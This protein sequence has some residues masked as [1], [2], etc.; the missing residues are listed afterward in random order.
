MRAAV[1]PTIACFFAHPALAQDAADAGWTAQTPQSGLQA[2]RDL[3][4]SQLWSFFPDATPQQNPDTADAFAAR[5]ATNGGLPAGI[6]DSTTTTAGRTQTVDADDRDWP[7]IETYARIQE[8]DSTGLYSAAA[9]LD[10]SPA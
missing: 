6:P 9:R 10:R 3:G 7:R 5:I 4:G 1:L 8:S 2:R